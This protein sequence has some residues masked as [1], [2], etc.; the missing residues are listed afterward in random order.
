VQHLPNALNGFREGGGMMKTCKEDN[1]IGWPVESLS[2]GLSSGQTRGTGVSM[3]VEG[4]GSGQ[5]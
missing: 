4:G 5:S 2:E 3:A 1:R